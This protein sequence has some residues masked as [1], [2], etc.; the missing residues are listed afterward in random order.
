MLLAELPLQPLNLA[1][2][3]HGSHPLHSVAPLAQLLV[4]R[5]VMVLV[6]GE[7]HVFVCYLVKAVELTW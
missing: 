6:G 7:E 5:G 1:L 2:G 4:V 3:E